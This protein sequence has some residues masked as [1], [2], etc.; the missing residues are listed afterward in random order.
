MEELKKEGND[1]FLQQDYNMA[2]EKYKE[3]LEL[4][5]LLEDNKDI[6]ILH[7]NLSSAYCK[8]DDFDLALDHAK[9]C[10]KLNFNWY[11]GWYRL[12][13]VL[14]KLNKTEE[15]KKAINKTLEICKKEEID[16]KYIL[17]LKE[18]IF[19]DNDCKIFSDE[20]KEIPDTFKNNNY[21]IFSDEEKKIPDTF[22]DSMPQFMSAMLNNPKIKEKLDN[23]NFKEKMLNNRENPLSML[24]DPDMTEVMLEMMKTFKS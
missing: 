9:K 21:K 14:F 6:S 8:I 22:K 18:N 24:S 23:Q 15:A 13:Y 12:S 11:K 1:F 7:S 5:E 19:K 16:D 17:E 3:A 2:I 4:S 20:E 10:I